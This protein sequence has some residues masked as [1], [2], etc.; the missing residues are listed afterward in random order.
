MGSQPTLPPT[1]WIYVW[2][3]C[4]MQDMSFSKRREERITL[5]VPSKLL[6]MLFLGHQS[7]T[8][9]DKTTV[10]NSFIM[11]KRAESST[12]MTGISQSSMT[13]RP[14]E[15][16][17]VPI[18]LHKLLSPDMLQLSKES[19][20]RKSFL[21]A[22]PEYDSAV[23]LGLVQSVWITQIWYEMCVYSYLSGCYRLQVSLHDVIKS[24]A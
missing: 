19:L 17:L 9:I 22:K 7:R 20:C 23:K 4:G 13:H 14:T 5:R 12:R 8:C 1:S 11:S 24:F 6:R 21:L 15:I 2:S 10:H 3:C 16:S 18:W